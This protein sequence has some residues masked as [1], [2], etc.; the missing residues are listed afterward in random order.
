M[1]LRELQGKIPVNLKTVTDLESSLRVGFLLF[2]AGDTA[3]IPAM[4]LSQQGVLPCCRGLILRGI[5][6]ATYSDDI[7]WR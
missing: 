2:I 3:R 5:T 1:T 4:L 6:N 7:T